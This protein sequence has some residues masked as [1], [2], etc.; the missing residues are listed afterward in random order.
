MNER[1]EFSGFDALVARAD[2][3]T[4]ARFRREHDLVAGLAEVKR[5][6][7]ARMREAGA[8]VE[9]AVPAP[10][11]ATGARGE[12]DAVHVFVSRRLEI[13]VSTT[14]A[15]GKGAHLDGWLAPPGEYEVTVVAG[16][17]TRRVES[18]AGGRFAVPAVAAG[19]VTVTVH[20]EPGPPLATP[21]I[22]L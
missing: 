11:P 13:T 21:E 15:A 17:E 20:L 10:C 6:A 14:E 16:D 3:R 12:G 5:R 1:P 9:I 18:D 2:R 4:A 19:P 8:H 7:G 22:E